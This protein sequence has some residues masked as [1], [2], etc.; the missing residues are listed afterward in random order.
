[1]P[2]IHYELKKDGL[3]R[4][5]QLLAEAISTFQPTLRDTTL[6]IHLKARAHAQERA[7]TFDFPID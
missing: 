1:M 5:N 2:A 6:S 4:N 3:Y 7:L